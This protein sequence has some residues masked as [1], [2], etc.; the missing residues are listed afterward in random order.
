M[1]LLTG[2]PIALSDEYSSKQNEPERIN[3]FAFA[4]SKEKITTANQYQL[5]DAP[6][7]SIAVVRILSPISKTDWCGDPGTQSLGRYISVAADNPNISSIILEIDSP[8]GTLS[9]TQTLVDTIKQAVAKKPVLAF[10]NEGM[11]ASAAYWIGSAAT[12]IYASQKTDLIGSIGVYQTMVDATKRWEDLGYKI[13][14][15]YAAQSSEKNEEYREFVEK[16]TTKLTENAVKIAANIFINAIKTNRG[17][18]ID[19]KQD[20]PFEGR[21]YYA[22]EAEKIGLIDGIK[23]FDQVVDRAYALSKD[24]NANNKSTPMAGIKFVA[25]WTWLAAQFGAASPETLTEEHFKIANDKGAE[26]ESQLVAA[27][28]R[29]A[30]MEAE[31]QSMTERAQLAEANAS[32]LQGIVDTYGDA[33]GATVSAPPKKE[34]IIDPEKDEISEL[35]HNQEADNNPYI[36]K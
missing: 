6:E 14:D 9:G 7:D 11:M 2:Q 31:V 1:S 3:P 20:D 24:P 23:N 10:V 13:K 16:G 19:V 30:E 25:A 15:V 12:E 34:E 8:G 4:V 33:P 21:L 27:N 28:S 5:N 18:K 26:L 35:S 36:N 17:D 22:Y 29:I 32:R